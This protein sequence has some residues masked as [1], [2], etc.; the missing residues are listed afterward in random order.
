MHNPPKAAQE[1]PLYYLISILE[2]PMDIRKIKRIAAIFVFAMFATMLILL[3]T[4]DPGEEVAQTPESNVGDN[5]IHVVTPPIE[6]NNEPLSPDI[7]IEEPSENLTEDSNQI[8]KVSVTEEVLPD[9]LRTIAEK[10]S[11][12]GMSAIVIE[13]GQISHAYSYGVRNMETGDP[14]NSASVL[15]VASVSGLI[16]SIGV[17]KLADEGIIDLDEPIGNYLGYTV[18][19]PY[20]QKPITL[21][22]IL[23]HTASISDYGAYDKVTNNELDYQTLREML[24][25]TY[26]K[27][28][29]YDLLPGYRYA[30]SNFGGAIIS[31]IVS[32]VTQKPFN[33]FMAE[34]LFKP[35]NVDAAFMS[36]EINERSNISTI[37]RQGKVSYSLDKMDSFSEKLQSISPED[38]YRCSHANL[39]IN[40]KDL[41]RITQ[42]LINGGNVESVSIL[43]K[44]AVDTMMETTANGTLYSDVGVGLYISK[45]NDIVD[46]RTLYGQQGGAYGATAMT[47]FDPQDKSGVVLLVN[48]SSIAV[49]DNG[50]SVM[51]SAVINEIYKSIIG[52]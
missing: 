22:Q 40:S 47:F 20:N 13:N 51:G 36:T 49:N 1:K 17:M 37:Y 14:F 11:V 18:V 39:Y 38:N 50:I 30:Y 35:L 3:A 52:N 7:N 15:R 9:S 24:S 25:G 34:I 33:D 8:D 21:R 16:S 42:L 48:G 28:N 19:N 4:I 29:F 41:A 27:S 26:A 46:G 10:Y 43:S 5:D 44:T 12:T 31:A 6:D 32:S 45:Y 2:R 23:T